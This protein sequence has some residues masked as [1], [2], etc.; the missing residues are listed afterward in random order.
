MKALAELKTFLTGFARDLRGRR[1]Y[2]NLVD[3]E[4]VQ[5]IAAEVAHGVTEVA[6]LAF[7][8][9]VADDEGLSLLERV[10]ADGEITPAE[11][12]SVMQAIAHIRRSRDIDHQLSD[13]ASA[14]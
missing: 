8:A 5:E 11:M 6:Q 9:R 3:V 12:P 1:D 2:R 7:T 14:S 10:A 4:A 13:A